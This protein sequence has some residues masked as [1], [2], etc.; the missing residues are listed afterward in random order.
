MDGSARVVLVLCAAVWT[1]PASAEGAASLS[2]LGLPLPDI[3]TGY[4]YKN[5]NPLAPIQIEMFGDL[6]CP[7]FRN[8]FPVLKEVADWYGPNLLCLKIHLFPLPY[9]KYAFLTHQVVHIIE[10]YVGINGTF[11][12]MDRVLADLEKFSGAVMNR[13]EGQVYNELLSIVQTL[14]VTADQYWTGL[15]ERPPNY[16]ARIEF[17]YACHRGVAATPTF[18]VN[19]IMVNPVPASA[20]GEFGLDQWKEALDPMLGTEEQ[21]QEKEQLAADGFSYGTCPS[22]TAQAQVTCPGITDGTSAG[23]NPSPVSTTVLTLLA[24]FALSGAHT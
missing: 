20:G 16:R 21:K 24:V 2:S 15:D 14:G 9:H 13:T 12:Y 10:P 23:T 19:G 5:G 11:D 7:D 18:F 22:K 1:L 3:P 4:V 6:V 17:K 8:A